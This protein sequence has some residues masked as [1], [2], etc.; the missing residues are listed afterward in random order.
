MY[1]Q[2]VR[3]SVNRADSNYTDDVIALLEKV[4]NVN[5]IVATA[6]LDVPGHNCV[7][8]SWSNFA[9]YSISFGPLLNTIQAVRCPSVGIINGLQVIF[10]TLPCGGLEVL[11]GV[12]EG[13]VERLEGNRL[14]GKYAERRA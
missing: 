5:Q 13:S 10:P 1:S 2:T 11:V 4:P 9:L 6:F 3:K 14:W 8:T 7:Q 12:E